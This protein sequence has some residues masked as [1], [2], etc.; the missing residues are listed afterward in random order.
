MGDNKKMLAKIHIAR[1]QLGMADEDYRA[2]LF[3]VIGV[4][5]AKGLGSHQYLAVLA[6]FKRLGFQPQNPKK[7]GRS[8]PKLASSRASMVKKIEA[9]LADA[10]R[11]WD[12]A[13][14]TAMRMFKIQRLEWLVDLQVQKVMQALIMDAARRKRAL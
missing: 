3:R 5:S 7:Q 8:R 4:R 13:D 12:Y 2:L 9:L 11:P 10:G 6:E 14:A 1:Q